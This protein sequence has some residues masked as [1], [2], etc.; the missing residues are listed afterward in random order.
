MTRILAALS[1]AATLA[2]I[3]LRALADGA[4]RV[5]DSLIAQQTRTP[6]TVPDWMWAE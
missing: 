6:E 3:V 1:L 2:G 4:E 5:S